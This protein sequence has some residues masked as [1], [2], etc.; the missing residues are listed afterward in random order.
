MLTKNPRTN[1]ILLKDW[2]KINVTKAQ[3]EF[4]EE[5]INLKKHNELIT[6]EDIDTKEVLFKWRC[7]EIKEFSERKQDK[8]LWEKVWI[9]GFWRRHNLVWFPDNCNCK[10]EFNCLPITFKYWLKENW[11]NINTDA[12]IT[13]SMRN[14]YKQSNNL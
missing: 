6:I 14:A 7:S 12:D 13:S 8:S 10:E 5:E 1:I 2:R 9:C 11:Y 4:I 3:S